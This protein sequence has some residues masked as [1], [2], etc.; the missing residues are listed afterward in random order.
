[1]LGSIGH[2]ELGCI[3]AVVLF[4]IAGSVFWV[5]ALVDC[6]TREPNEGNSKIVWVIIIA[7]THF[8]GAVLYVLIRRP[9][10]V[11]QLGR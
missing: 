10:R 8:L 2:P 6:A 7:L 5:W 9:D 11:R 4:G 1:M 3:L